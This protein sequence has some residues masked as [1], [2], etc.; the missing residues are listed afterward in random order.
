MK[1]LCLF[2]AF[3]ILLSSVSM[4]FSV[5]D[6]LTNFKDYYSRISG[7]D[8]AQFNPNVCSQGQCVNNQINQ[9][10]F[11]VCTQ[12]QLTCNTCNGSPCVMQCQNNAWVEYQYCAQSCSNGQCVNNQINQMQFQVCT[13]GQLTCNTCNGSPCVMQCQN[14]AWV[15][16]QYCAQSCSNGQCVNNQINQMQFQV[17][18]Q[19]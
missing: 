2:L 4:A 10:Q 18:T 12:G 19:G 15:E 8:I 11:Q 6:F 3:I 5:R 13:Q 17:C 1:K 9:M 16:Y 7:A 14:N